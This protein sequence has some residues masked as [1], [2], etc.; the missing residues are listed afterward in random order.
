MPALSL[1]EAHP[2]WSIAEVVREVMEQNADSA[3]TLASC[4]RVSHAFSEPALE[5]LWRELVGLDRLLSILRKSVVRTHMPLEDLPDMRIKRYIISAPIDDKEWTRF[6]Y[7]ANFVRSY[8]TDSERMDGIFTATLLDKSEGKPLLPRLTFFKWAKQ[9]EFSSA[10]LLFLSPM[11]RFVHL[12]FFSYGGSTPVGSQPLPEDLTTAAAL[13]LV[14]GRAPALDT[15]QIQACH[16]CSLDPVPGFA[17]LRSLQITQSK[18]PRIWEKIAGSLPAL[19]S[20]T[21]YMT[22]QSLDEDILRAKRLPEA[23]F[24][25]LTQLE[26]MADARMVPI[27]LD[28][29]HAPCL[30]HLHLQMELKDH[31]CVRACE[32]VASRFA[33]SLRSFE[34][35][36]DDDYDDTSP[37]EFGALFSPLYALRELVDVQLAIRFDTEIVVTVDDIA[38]MAEAWPNVQHLKLPFTAYPEDEPEVPRMPITALETFARRC[39]KLEGL[40]MLI[41]DPWPLAD[42]DLAT[43]PSYSNRLSRLHLV[44]GGWPQDMVEKGKLYFKHLFPNAKI[45]FDVDLGVHD[46]D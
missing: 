9:D 12:N 35:E 16:I 45:W 41:P 6:Q 44:S 30:R 8:T 33:Q 3:K 31:L 14:H 20:L 23:R 26:F 24:G 4:A 17:H 13:R 27:V 39:P 37:R 22:T 43:V 1:S 34:L 25:Q 11:L 46:N 21:V 36:L 5:V 29:L 38:R 42:L 18:D 40:V 7:Y 28:L 15:L 2:V 10:F 32:I 19:Q